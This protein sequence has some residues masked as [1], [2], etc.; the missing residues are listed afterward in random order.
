MRILIAE[1]TEDSRIIL[2]KNLESAGYEVRG[3][4]NGA[5][6]L[7]IAREFLPEMII[8]DILMPEMDGFTFCRMAKQDST[9]SK[10]PF[11]FYT[12]TYTDPKDEQLALSLGASKFLIKPL[13]NDQ[14]LK[15]INEIILTFKNNS[16]KVPEH[17]SNPTPVLMEMYDNRLSNKLDKK[18]KELE[19]EHR[20]L[21]Q[22]E[23]ELQ[24][25][26]ARFR[27]L[28]EHAACSIVCISTDQTITEFNQEAE[29]IFGRKKEDVL[30]KNFFNL[31]LKGEYSK[32]FTA[33][34][35]EAISGAEVKDF[36][37]PVF[38]PSE[39][40]RH[41]I[42]NISPMTDNN[43][44]II[45]TI[46]IGHD[47]TQY[48]KANRDLKES[49]ARFRAIFDNAAD[50]ILL[51]NPEI[52]KTITG[53]RTLTEMLGYST[54]ELTSLM[55]SDIHTPEDLK[56]IEAERAASDNS[57]PVIIHDISVI[58]HDG[59]VFQ[60]DISYVTIEIDQQAVA[61]INIKDITI[62]NKLE[63]QL[64]HSQKLEAVGQLAGGIAHDFNNLLTAVISYGSL[65]RMKLPE[66]DN[67]MHYINQI[68][69]ISDRGALLTKSLLAF[70]RKQVMNIQPVSL[71]LLLAGVEKLLK[72]MLGENIEMKIQ[73]PEDELYVMADISQIEHILINLASNARD[74]MPD[75]GTFTIGI[76]LFTIDSMFKQT[77]G[78]GREGKYALI[79]VS[80]TGSG[81]TTDTKE[82]IFEP[83]FT[84][85]DV[86][87]GTGLGL[88]MAYGI[89][90]QHKG[91][92]NV[93]SEPKGGT[94]FRILIPAAKQPKHI[95]QT[96][97]L[98]DPPNGTG[99]IL[100][101]E[102]EDE[103]REALKFILE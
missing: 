12:A 59:T 69:T 41:I 102:D 97:T 65:L 34:V 66:N 11:V 44:R 17:P 24:A 25:S 40:P 49:E 94:T 2:K 57:S 32:A 82:K 92:I 14:F 99:T 68:L 8:S 87:Q 89:M 31:C 3:A 6:A 37:C 39:E 33:K 13:E 101:A 53:N 52:N 67:M 4:A 43:S 45:G 70:S 76:S 1:D 91:Y 56:F 9:L 86:G 23:S 96:K 103:V 50:G 84:T 58:R 98:P 60:A 20:A 95:E 35:D 47:T 36:E 5:E 54:E 42:W 7:K 90:K 64:Q 15:I 71:S 30:G 79:S 16:L 73:I 38:T 80:D 28:V 77:H 62:Q 75:G 61:L 55:L 81:M 26:E 19:K 85:K 46:A 18:L 27:L 10:V 63:T 29:K 100:L 93:Y 74:A 83:F 78:Y 88:S 48:K 21:K 51:I 72:R 22:K